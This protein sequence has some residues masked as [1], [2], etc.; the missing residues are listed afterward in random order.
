MDYDI[1]YLIFGV[2][3]LNPYDDSDYE[4]PLIGDYY[5]WL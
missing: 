1:Y 3:E 5:E 2:G 4:L